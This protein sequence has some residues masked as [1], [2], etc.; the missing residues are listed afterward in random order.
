M[1]STLSQIFEVR[2]V[3]SKQKE[4]IVPFTG[5]EVEWD[6][7]SS[8]YFNQSHSLWPH[9]YQVK[10]PASVITIINPFKFPALDLCLNEQYLDAIDNEIDFCE[11]LDRITGRYQTTVHN[12]QMRKGLGSRWSM[13]ANCA[14][15]K[16]TYLRVWCCLCGTLRRS[17]YCALLSISEFAGRI[18]ALPICCR[19]W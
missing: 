5:C 13:Y 14:K 15:L 11:S 10:L 3:E 18:L 16:A 6:S 12:L 9:V 17:C 7:R 19:T 1:N 2:S 4:Q 8:N